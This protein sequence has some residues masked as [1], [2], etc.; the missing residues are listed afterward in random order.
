MTC[1]ASNNHNRFTDMVGWQFQTIEVGYIFALDDNEDLFV[2]RHDLTQGARAL[3][4]S[5]DK[6][7]IGKKTRGLTIVD[8]VP[9]G[10]VLR[11]ID[12]NE[13]ISELGD[14]VTFRC[15]IENGKL[16]GRYVNTRYAQKNINGR[17]GGRPEF[18]PVFVTR[19]ATGH[20]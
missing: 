14:I 16:A 10:T 2:G 15:C 20:G 8:I 19:I 5:V 11:V 17:D 13:D 7:F 4:D 3:P 6:R 1:A 18:D 12:V 9:A